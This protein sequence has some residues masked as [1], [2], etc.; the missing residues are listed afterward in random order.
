MPPGGLKCE[1]I[2][3]PPDAVSGMSVRATVGIKV[4]IGSPA[5]LRHPNSNSLPGHRPLPPVAGEH[6]VI[7]FAASQTLRQ[8]E[9]LGR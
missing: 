7:R 1:D 8:K 3:P 2:D 4:N 6:P 9:R 5:P